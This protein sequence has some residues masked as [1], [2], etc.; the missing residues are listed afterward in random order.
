MILERLAELEQRL[1]AERLRLLDARAAVRA[2]GR[3][4]AQLEGAVGVLRELRDA[5]R[6]NGPDPEAS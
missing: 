4:C 5:A 3:R 6:P 1:G 2:L